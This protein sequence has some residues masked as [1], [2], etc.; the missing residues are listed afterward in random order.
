[1]KKN[2]YVFI[3]MLFFLLSVVDG[4]AQEIN[5]SVIDDRGNTKLLGVIDKDG[6]TQDPFKTWFD[7]H[8]ESYETNSKSIRSIRSELKNYEIKVFMGTWCGD[9]R[10]EVPRFYKILD[11][12]NFPMEKLTVIAVDNSRKNYKKSPTGEEK[13]R[14]IHRVPTFIFYKDGKEVNRIVEHPKESLE[15]DMVRILL[16]KEYSPN[17][18]SIEKVNQVMGQ[19]GASYIKDSTE[20]VDFFKTLVT[21]ENDLNGYGYVLLYA[22]SFEKAIAVFTLNTKLFPDT[23]NPY[24]S[25]A[26]AYEISD[27]KAKALENYRLALMT[28]EESAA[29]V[30]LRKKIESLSI[31]KE[32]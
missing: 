8:Y 26:E 21:N 31:A 17:Y 15:A 24:D 12:M 5:L 30:R 16:S 20:A 9:S 2:R 3:L 25:L 18:S 19:K 22:E 27:N 7:Q 13:G 4:H 11:K 29:V 6:L 28:I 10:Q 1:M 14:N 32:Q 23:M